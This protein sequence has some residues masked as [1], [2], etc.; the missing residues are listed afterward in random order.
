MGTASKT[1][2]RSTVKELGVDCQDVPGVSGF[3]VIAAMEET[4]FDPVKATGCRV[5]G[6]DLGVGDTQIQNGAALSNFYVQ[7]P[8]G[9]GCPTVTPGTIANLSSA[10]KDAA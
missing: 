4:V 10:A 1:V 6:F 8:N 5:A 9:A 7:Y 2:F 3:Q